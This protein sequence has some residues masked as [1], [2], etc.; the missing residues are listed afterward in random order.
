M[1]LYSKPADGSAPDKRLTEGTDQLHLV[2][3]SWADDGKTL[4]ITKAVDPNTGFDI[5]ILPYKAASTPQPL[6]NTRWTKR[7]CRITAIHCAA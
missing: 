7:L 1:D 3:K 6:I 4:I 5:E 2:P